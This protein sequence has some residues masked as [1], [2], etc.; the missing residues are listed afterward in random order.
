MSIK[1]CKSRK[2]QFSGKCDFESYGCGKSWISPKNFDYLDLT[3]DFWKK[4]DI[5]EL[6]VEYTQ[7]LNEK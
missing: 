5:F 2:T 4:G 3:V 1:N 7:E 6:T